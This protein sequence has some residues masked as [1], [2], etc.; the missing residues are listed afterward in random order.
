[1]LS[2]LR[3]GVVNFA[4]SLELIDRVM[5]KAAAGARRGD[6]IERRRTDMAS[7]AATKAGVARIDNARC[8]RNRRQ[9]RGRR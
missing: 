6:L 5:E 8:I 4:H 7:D 3:K 9:E 2:R 1:M